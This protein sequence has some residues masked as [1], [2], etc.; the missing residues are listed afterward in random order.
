MPSKTRK[1]EDFPPRYSDLVRAFGDSGG[2]TV[3]VG[4]MTKKI[5]FALRSDLYRYRNAISEEMRRTK[6]KKIVNQDW[7][8][9]SNAWENL[10][11]RI[12]GEGDK[13]F[14]HLML[15]PIVDAIAEQ[16]GV[17]IM[18]PEIRIAPTYMTDEPAGEEEEPQP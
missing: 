14:L 9:Y 12:D 3:T 7:A 16:G 15:N 18:R 10:F 6:A 1:P 8:P 11:L 2:E 5:A 17:T 13:W 4:P